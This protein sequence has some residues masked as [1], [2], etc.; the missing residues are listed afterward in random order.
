MSIEDLLAEAQVI[1]DETTPGANTHERIGQMFINIIN[2]L[3][4]RTFQAPYNKAAG[5]FFTPFSTNAALTSAAVVNNFIRAMPF[6]VKEEIT[7]DRAIFRCVTTQT[8]DI[9][10]GI[11]TAD[12][13]GYP[14]AL[15]PDSEVVFTPNASNTTFNEDFANPVTLQPGLYY[16]AYLS[17]S[18]AT[19]L[20]Y[21]SQ[22]QDN[23][24]SLVAGH[25]GSNIYIA[26]SYQSALSFGAL[27]STFPGGA[28]QG[29]SNGLYFALR[30]A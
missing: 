28:T 25:A 1:Y 16:A 6:L 26:T 17:S 5:N 23:I 29:T 20:Q 30:L 11:Y 21:L 18:V 9:G 2:T 8:G 3:A 14:D 13:D 10:W 22:A 27:P 4:E 7:V 15:I 19:M 12:A 24:L